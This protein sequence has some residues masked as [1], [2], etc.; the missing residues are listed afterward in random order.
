MSSYFYKPIS[1]QILRSTYNIN[2]R[3]YYF[4]LNDQ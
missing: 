1:T 3:F 4:L 2:D